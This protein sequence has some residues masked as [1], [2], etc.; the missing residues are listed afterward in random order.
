[1]KKKII[2]L[3]LFL[4]AITVFAYVFFIYDKEKTIRNLPFYGLKKYETINGKTDTVFHTVPDFSFI[5]QDG[6]TITQKNF[7]G[8]VYVTDFFFTTCHTI[9]PIMSSQMERIAEK[10]KGNF[11]VKFLSHTVDP[12]IDTVEQLKRYALE[13]NADPKQ[14]M[15]VTG[16]KKLLYSIARKGYLLNAE[17]GDGGP[18]DFIHTQNFALVDIDKHIRGFYDGTDSIIMN[19]L[20]KDIDLLLA[21]YH[22]KKKKPDN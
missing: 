10:F 9:C 14:W 8:S 2:Y 5:N 18:D 13:H 15:F 22:N 12:E 7:N 4:I 19:Q 6:Q 16:D 3:F 1:M 21:E 11:E 20:M 17:Q